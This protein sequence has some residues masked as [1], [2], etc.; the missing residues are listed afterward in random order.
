MDELK[1]F[2]GHDYVIND[3]ITICHPTLEDIC[4]FGEK[5]Y[6]SLVFD[7]TATPPDYK[8]FLFDNGIDYE[9]I[10]EFELFGSICKKYDAEESYILFGGLNLSEF[11]LA[12]HNPTEEKILYN[13]NL[14]VII[15]RSIYELIV[16]FIRKINGIEKNMEQAGNEF[17]K[18]FL[19]E[20]DRQNKEFLK[21]K[22]YKSNLIP[23]ISSMVNCADFKYNHADVWDLPIYSFIDSVNRIKKIKSCN[24]LMQGIYSGN[25]DA[26]KI[27]K[28]E[29]NW[30]GELN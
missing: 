3:K 29:L 30:F 1:L 23:L 19:I 17:T 14:D 6:Y 8:A 10:T 20:E 24:Y 22:P 26:T 4:N 9:A 12:I 28:K 21:G 5:E 2:R 7:I 15:D 16:G 18:K 25:I 13:S 11:E 27:S